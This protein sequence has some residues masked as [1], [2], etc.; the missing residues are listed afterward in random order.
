MES[1]KA[2]AVRHLPKLCQRISTEAAADLP[3][4]PLPASC[5]SG[6]RAFALALNKRLADDAGKSKT[7][8][9]LLTGV[10]LRSSVAGGRRRPR[11]H[12]LGAARRPRRAVAGRPRQLRRCAGGAGPGRPLKD[13]RG[14]TSA[15]RAPWCT[16][17][18]GLSSPPTSTP[19]SRTTRHIRAW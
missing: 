1:L 9:H 17:R 12:P 10:R 19:S 11:A 7:Q 8:P 5:R 4:L 15:S 13:G 16:T 3:A 2:F 18:R 14:R 6:Q